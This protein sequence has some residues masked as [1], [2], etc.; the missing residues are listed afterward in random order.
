ME[1]TNAACVMIGEK[2]ADLILQDW[3]ENGGLVILRN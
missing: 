2:G 3:Q 1:I